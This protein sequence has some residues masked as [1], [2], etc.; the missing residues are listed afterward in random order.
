M[1]D[2]NIIDN[3]A[4]Y[5][6]PAV[7][8]AFLK[9]KNIVFSAIPVV[10]KNKTSDKLIIKDIDIRETNNCNYYVKYRLISED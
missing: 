4:S 8:Y 7:L 1:S 3:P 10:R 5:L 2:E 9:G 6:S